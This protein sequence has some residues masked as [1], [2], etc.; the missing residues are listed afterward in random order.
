M[1]PRTAPPPP[2]PE[3]EEI[4]KREIGVTAVSPGLARFLLVGF[5]IAIWMVPVFE[6]AVTRASDDRASAWSH[7]A[8]LRDLPATL[9]ERDETASTDGW[10]ARLVAANRTVIS[11]LVAFEHALE[12]ES[13]LAGFLR[14]PAQ[15]VLTRWLGVGNEQ[16]YLGHDGWLFYRSD[17]DYVTR[18]GFLLPSHLERRRGEASEW[19]R[20]PQPDPR[21]AILDFK[22]Q[23]DARGAARVVVPPPGK[24]TV[25]PRE[26]ARD[27]AGSDAPLQNPSYA[28]FVRELREHGVLVFDPSEALVRAARESGRPQYLRT[29]THWRPE[30]VELVAVE[31]GRFIEAHVPLPG[32]PDPG[33]GGDRVSIAGTGDIVPMLGLSEN[34]TLYPV[35]TVQARRIQSPDGAPWRPSRDADVLVLG[36]S[37]SNIYAVPSMNWGESAGLVEQLSYV[38]RRPLDRL[39]QND[40]AAFATREALARPLLGGGSR[41]AGKRLVIYQFASRE[42]AFGDWQVIELP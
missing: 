27:R 24:P 35:E 40:D 4:A 6:W 7:L 18:G 15:Y 41:L 37:F 9:L 30:A 14:P 19:E 34:Q 26:L 20:P 25:H 17:V 1:E 31:L 16:A 11:A 21:P 36:D 42:L 28:Q 22:R 33:Y 3:R 10:W 38:L 5:I 23:L 13:H 12:D 39:V 29:D 2:A 8:N 32:V